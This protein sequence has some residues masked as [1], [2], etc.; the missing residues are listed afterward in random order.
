[1]GR[2]LDILVPSSR[3]PRLS[4]LIVHSEVDDSIKTALRD[5]VKRGDLSIRLD[6]VKKVE[7]SPVLLERWVISHNRSGQTFE[8]TGPSNH[9]ILKSYQRL[10]TLMRSIYSL[11]RLLPRRDEDALP[12]LWFG[13]DLVLGCSASTSQSFNA[14]TKSFA[15]PAIVT[16]S[17]H[18]AVACEY[19]RFP[20]IR[21]TVA[22]SQ[23]QS[24]DAF[25]MVSHPHVPATSGLA[26]LLREGSR[27]QPMT[28]QTPPTAES[29]AARSLGEELDHARS[30][31][32]S[33]PPGKGRSKSEQLDQGGFG[34][35]P[36]SATASSLLQRR[37]REVGPIFMY[38]GSRYAWR[39]T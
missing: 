3:S 18:L 20:S 36:Q 22:P 34:S 6:L 37:R 17:G 12:Q 38:F 7:G 35:S 15:M 2:I 8:D 11:L 29:S 19:R 14:E 31:P 28:A 26:A 4:L 23:E 27:P 5:Y 25:E 10:T 9:L 30:P 1:M 24:G 33:I 32:M 39:L 13:S 21:E 16:T